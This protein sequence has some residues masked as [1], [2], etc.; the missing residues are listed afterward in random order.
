[1]DKGNTIVMVIIVVL[2]VA[3]AIFYMNPSENHRAVAVGICEL[4]C[5]NVTALHYNGSSFCISHNI[6]FGYSCALSASTN[7][8]LCNSAPT[9]YVGSNCQLVGVK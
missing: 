4:A 2:V 8:S 3:A 7:P 5:Q 6:S 1:M 9:I